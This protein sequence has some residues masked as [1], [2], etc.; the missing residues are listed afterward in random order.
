MRWVRPVAATM[1][2]QAAAQ[3]KMDVKGDSRRLAGNES[4]IIVALVALSAGHNGAEVFDARVARSGSQV[5]HDV[6]GS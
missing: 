4:L 5:Q 2:S 3:T 6:G 1:N